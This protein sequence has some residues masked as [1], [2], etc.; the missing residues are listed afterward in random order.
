MRALLLALLFILWLLISNVAYANGIQGRVHVGRYERSIRLNVYNRNSGIRV[1]NFNDLLDEDVDVCF[2]YCGGGIS[3]TIK[4]PDPDARKP[5]NL[6]ACIY[7]ITGTLVYE[8]EDK[9]CAY[10]W[11]DKNKQRIE[12]RRQ[13]SQSENSPR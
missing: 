4:N 2:P 5:E 13:T 8:R 3:E 12:L 11:S 7:D 10:K 6:T 1:W 9:A